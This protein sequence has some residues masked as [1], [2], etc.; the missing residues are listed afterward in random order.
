MIT[1]FDIQKHLDYGVKTGFLNGRQEYT[2][3]RS[4]FTREVTSSGAFEGYADMGETPWPLQN[5]GSLGVGGTGA[6]G[7]VVTNRMTVGQAITVLGGE[8]RKITVYNVD[9][10]IALGITHNAINDDRVGNVEQWATDSG[11]AFEKHMDYLCFSILNQGEGTTYG[12]GYDGLSLFNDSHIDPGAEYQT[13]QDN[14]YAV[15]LSLDNF[16]TV[17]VAGSE[18]KD[19]RGQPTGYN[20]NLLIVSPSKERIAAQIATN[21]ED[22][23]TANRAVNPYQ[24][25]VQYIVAPGGWLD[26]TAWYLV[27]PNQSVKPVYLQVRERPSLTMWDDHQLPSGVRY[28]KWFARY[29]V[30][31]GQWRT[32]IQGNT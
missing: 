17:Y 31:V 28:Y 24:G 32:A 22:Y 15:A 10:T 25:R 2:P 23:G 4:A 16:E 1:R 20:H 6:A 13:G 5:G 12:K 9:W 26:A 3:I 21:R 18:F 19:S 30:F 14:K 7:E 27:D 11:R 29:T 8:E